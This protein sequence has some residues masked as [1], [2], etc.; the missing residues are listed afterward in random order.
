MGTANVAIISKAF[1]T[2]KEAEAFRDQ[3]NG[4]VKTAMPTKTAY[5]QELK[6]DALPTFD[7]GTDLAQ[8]EK[9]PVLS[10]LQ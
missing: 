6:T 8:V 4:A 3:V 7:A 1:S 2:S 10:F 5:V 9:H